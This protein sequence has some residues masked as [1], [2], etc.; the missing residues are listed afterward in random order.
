MSY[1]SS[2][3]LVAVGRFRFAGIGV[4]EP[5]FY[6]GAILFT[7]NTWGARRWAKNRRTA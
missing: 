3:Y 4:W 1:D 6:L 7:L 5:W 2:G